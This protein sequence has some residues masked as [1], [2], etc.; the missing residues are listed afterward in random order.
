M[1]TATIKKT[2]IDRLRASVICAHLEKERA[3]S[4]T[5]SMAVNHSALPAVKDK[6]MG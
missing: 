3:E 5:M 4:M 1:L 2:R 6:G